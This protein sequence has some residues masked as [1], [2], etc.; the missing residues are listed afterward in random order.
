MSSINHLPDSD[1]DSAVAFLLTKDVPKNLI[2][3]LTHK[4]VKE[5]AEHQG[6]KDPKERESIV[7]FLKTINF[8][9]HLLPRLTHKEQKELAVSRGWKPME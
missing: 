9:Q 1:Y 7:A 6:W 8:P 2:T 4:A 5:L 3:K